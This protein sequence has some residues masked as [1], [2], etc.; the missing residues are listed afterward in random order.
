MRPVQESTSRHL[1]AGAEFD[2]RLFA[3]IEPLM[4]ND[5]LKKEEK[6]VVGSEVSWGCSTYALVI[7][8]SVA[9]DGDG[10]TG[11]RSVGNVEV[12]RR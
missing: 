11:S 1:V 6:P 4:D 7:L 12:W 3:V 8:V 9:A 10:I 2:R 5:V